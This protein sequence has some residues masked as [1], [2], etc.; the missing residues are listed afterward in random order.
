MFP[1]SLFPPYIFC[2]FPLLC[3]IVVSST[4]PD[5]LEPPN[6]FPTS[7]PFCEI[8]TVVAS[9]AFPPPYTFGIVPSTPFNITFVF[10]VDTLFPPPYTLLVIVPLF[11]VTFVVPTVP[12]KLLPPNTFPDTPPV[13]STFVVSTSPITFEPP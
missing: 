6:K 8:F 9:A 5:V 10:M 4:L 11:I 7:A 13:T 12:P 1:P 3:I 2:V